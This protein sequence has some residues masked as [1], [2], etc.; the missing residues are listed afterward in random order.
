[1][2]E[3]PE[4]DFS[5]VCDLCARTVAPSDGHLWVDDRDLA[6]VQ[7]LTAAWEAEHPD[8]EPIQVSNLVTRPQPA[9]WHVTHTTCDAV[10]R[11]S[12]YSI[13]LTRIQTFR[14]LVGW[15]A[16]LMGKNWL[17]HTDWDDLIANALGA[18]DGRLLS[19]YKEPWTA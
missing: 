8:A 12:G 7:R 1:M 14:D 13:E 2:A 4:P 19:T 16:H 10:P 9:R 6:Q 11:S 17:Q 18:G 3:N 15:T 5:G